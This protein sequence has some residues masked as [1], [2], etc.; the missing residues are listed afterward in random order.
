MSTP[1]K[2]W[3]GTLRVATTEVGLTTDESNILDASPEIDNQV[4]E[5][6]EKGSRSPTDIMEGNM[7]LSVRIRKYYLD[8]TWQA[9]CYS[10]T[11]LTEYYVRVYP[12][13][14]AVGKPYVTYLGKFANWRLEGP[15][16][17][18]QV[19]GMDFTGKTVTTGTV[20]A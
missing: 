20:P 8:N 3:K 13:G 2:G 12:Q 19:E 16:D 14:T 1:V 18:E 5:A 10:A 17:G 11:A 6:Y 9:Y 15:Q 7:R 4:T